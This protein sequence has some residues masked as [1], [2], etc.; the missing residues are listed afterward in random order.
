M[1]VGDDL[2]AEPVGRVGSLEDLRHGL[3]DLLGL[4]VTG[5]RRGELFAQLPQLAQ[6]PLDLAGAGGGVEFGLPRA[7]IPDQPIAFGGHGRLAAG[8]KT[9]EDLSVLV[10]FIPQGTPGDL[11][12]LKP[13]AEGGVFA[14]GPRQHADEP[15]ALVGDVREV[16]GA[17]QLAVGDVKEVL[18]SGQLAKHFPGLAVRLVVGGVAAGDAEV[19]GHATVLG[20]RENVQQLLQVGAVVLVMAEGDRQRGATQVAFLFGRRDLGPDEGDGRRVVVQFIQE[21]LELLDDV[22]HHGQDQG[23]RVGQKQPIQGAAHAVIVE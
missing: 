2:D 1:L 11:P 14:A 4:A 23:G 17:G 18:P 16:V 20:H 8:R 7:V 19:D 13:L 10:G 12:L 9:V 22:T 15:P 3:L 6:G 21:D 5:P